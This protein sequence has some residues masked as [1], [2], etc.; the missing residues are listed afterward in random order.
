MM[1][2]PLSAERSIVAETQNKPLDTH[3]EGADTPEPVREQLRVRGPLEPDRLERER[4]QPLG[5][6]QGVRELREARRV[7]PPLHLDVLQP[8]RL[9]HRAREGH[10]VALLGQ[11]APEDEAAHAGHAREGARGVDHPEEE[12]EGRDVRWAHEE[13]EVQQLVI[14]RTG[15]GGR[16]ERERE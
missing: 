8:R 3:R 12:R 5:G 4:P 11:R 2:I 9:F 10:R 6:A 1:R 14:G 15:I 7:H 13:V 16:G